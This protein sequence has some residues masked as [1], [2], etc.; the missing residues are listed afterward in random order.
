M[1]TGKAI[2][3]ILFVLGWLGF[4][5]GLY[6]CFP[7]TLNIL[8][9]VSISIICILF[10]WLGWGFAHYPTKHVWHDYF[11][12]TLKILLVITCIIAILYAGC[13][14]FIHSMVLELGIGIIVL[15]LGCLGIVGWIQ[16]HKIATA[17]LLLPFIF[18]I[19]ATIL[20]QQTKS[21]LS[22]INIYSFFSGITAGF[23]FLNPMNVIYF[24]CGIAFFIWI[25]ISIVRNN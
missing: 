11:A 4:V 8:K 25:I 2:G 16:R 24:L 12:R 3:W 13:M 22:A 14:L 15:T 9:W 1:A 19:I 6:L 10:I 23:V 18:G 7:I 5:A 17:F 20:P 21:V